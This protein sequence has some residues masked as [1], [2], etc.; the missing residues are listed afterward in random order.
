VSEP[1]APDSAAPTKVQPVGS[2]SREQER[3]SFGWSLLCVFVALFIA[4]HIAEALGFTGHRLMRGD[5]IWWQFAAYIGVA[6]A[7]Y[8]LLL[9]FVEKRLSRGS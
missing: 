4:S 1:T 9:Y 5:T 6:V 2:A 3:P 7:I 8:R